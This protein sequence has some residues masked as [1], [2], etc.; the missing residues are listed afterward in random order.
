MENLVISREYIRKNY[1]HKDKI[2]KT[3]Q[4]IEELLKQ[5]DYHNIKDKEERQFYKNQYMQY[6]TA[7]NILKGLLEETKDENR[8][9]NNV[10]IK[11]E[12]SADTNK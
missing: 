6:I 9:T 2:I 7:R 10:Q 4:E 5:I 3:I 1:I 11:K 8:N 12:Q